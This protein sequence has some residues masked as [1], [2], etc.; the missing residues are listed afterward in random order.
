MSVYWLLNI[1]LWIVASVFFYIQI[2]KHNLPRLIVFDV[3]VLCLLFGLLGGHLATA[4]LKPWY[5]T[6]YWKGFFFSLEGWR[7]GFASFG[8]IAGVIVALF[9]ISKL[10]HLSLLLITDLSVPSLFIGSTIGRL[11]CFFNGCCYGAPSSVPWAVSFNRILPT[12]PSH[13]VQL[14]ESALSLLVF[15]V[16]LP[17]IIRWPQAKPGK[18]NFTWLCLLIYFFERSFLEIFRIGGTSQVI[19]MGLSR[20]LL[21]SMLGSLICLVLL[22]HNLKKDQALSR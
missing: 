6:D 1:T 22:T 13:P 16:V 17:L 8:V 9:L 15:L 20:I 19:F 7:S 3:A 18:G 10:H 12:P 11:G 21:L 5:F 4:I 2:R 14:Y